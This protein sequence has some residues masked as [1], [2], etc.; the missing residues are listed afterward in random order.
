MRKSRLHGPSISDQHSY[1][2]ETEL[3]PRQ[4]EG[5]IGL[6]CL[7]EVPASPLHDE[8]LTSPCRLALPLPV[9]ARM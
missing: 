8:G 3:P 4:A 7:P 5:P 6:R 1:F 2:L 9:L